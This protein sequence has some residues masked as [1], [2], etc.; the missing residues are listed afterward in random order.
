MKLALLFAC[1]L[2]YTI[3][4]AQDTISVY[5]DNGSP[6]L[7]SAARQILDSL[8]YHNILEPGRRYSIVGYT[9]IVGRED[10]N[11]SL[12][13]RRARAVRAYIE[14]FGVNIDSAYGAGEIAKPE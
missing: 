8:A 4:P 3:C 5:F 7:N 14:G 10:A 2:A 13:A 6:A 1:I 9:D 11:I 12:S